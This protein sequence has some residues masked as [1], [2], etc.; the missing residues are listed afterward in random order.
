MKQVLLL[1]LFN[2]I[3]SLIF[4]GALSL[5][6]WHLSS[7]FSYQ[8]F[9]LQPQILSAIV[10]IAILM[11]IAF[12]V[13]H[14]ISAAN[15]SIF[16]YVYSVIIPGLVWYTLGEGEIFQI[17]IIIVV[18]AI[19]RC[20]VNFKIKRP[21]YG[22]LN[23][24]GIIAIVILL[25]LFIALWALVATRGT[26]NFKMYDVYLY[27]RD[28]IENFPGIFSYLWPQVT[29]ALIPLAIS[30]SL[31]KK[32]WTS[33]YILVA[34]S[35]ALFASLHHK[36]MLLTPFILAGI[37]YAQGSS[38]GLRPIIVAFCAF[39]IIAA[40]EAVSYEYMDMPTR[41][42]LINVL[43]VR[44]IFFVPVQ[45]DALY[46]EYFSNNPLF[47]WASSKISFGLIDTNYDATAPFLIG[48][49]FF[50]R[51]G[52]SA[53]SGLIASGYAN[54]GIIGILIYTFLL[55]I[56]IAILDSHGRAIG[57]RIVITSCLTLVHTIMTSSDIFTVLLTGGLG[58]LLIALSLMPKLN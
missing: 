45:L 39:A 19:L 35:I 25:S 18:F 9:A 58:T 15:F 51:E 36:A 57:H 50:G 13:K 26:L 43:L 41:T 3:T 56:C 54:A 38:Q 49:V 8:F 16:V 11:S 52:M 42:G 33:F 47:Y 37:Y 10:S 24:K 28:A 31:Y 34:I 23:A 22:R 46:L 55:S 5:S 40:A 48:S 17:F 29:N 6:F 20:L 32:W 27:R 12:F 2:F 53:N 30:V 44:R 14:S 7:E 21:V 1:P 4:F